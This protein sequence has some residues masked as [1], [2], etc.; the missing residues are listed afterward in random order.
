MRAWRLA[1]RGDL[2]AL[3]AF[4]R[5][6]EA[7]AAGLVARLLRD[8]SLALPGPLRGGLWLREGEGGG[9]RSV[10]LGLPGGLWMPQFSEGPKE[11]EGLAPALS[12]DARRAFAQG[13]TV[14]ASIIGPASSVAAFEA[15][16]GLEPD[17]R[18][19]YLLMVRPPWSSGP[20]AGSGPGLRRAAPPDLDLLVPLQKAYEEEEVITP[21]HVFDEEGSRAFLAKSLREQLVVV[22]EEDREGGNSVLGKA[23]TNARAFSLDQIGGVYVLPERRGKGL[24]KVLMEYLL[25]LTAKEGRGASLF[26][27]KSNAAALA[28]YAGLGF[29]GLDDFRADYIRP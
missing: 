9:I 23:G 1:R 20:P 24:G 2:E 6:Q 13:W 25:S 27:K 28:L 7:R 8:G 4:L 3:E 16:L 29:E 26:V 12:A 21:I 15:A 14:P 22:A 11:L 5:S 17:W 10:L 18:V 19:D